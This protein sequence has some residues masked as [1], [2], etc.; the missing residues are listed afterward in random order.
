MFVIAVVEVAALFVL[1]TSENIKNKYA[2]RC[3]CDG[4]FCGIAISHLVPISMLYIGTVFD[5]L[6]NIV[7]AIGFAYFSYDNYKRWKN[8]K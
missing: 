8:V 7:F 1:L 6:C 2:A 5:I 4:I 3:V